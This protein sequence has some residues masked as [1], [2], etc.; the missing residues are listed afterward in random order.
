MCLW[1]LGESSLYRRGC[2]DADVMRVDAFVVS[3][4]MPFL[5]WCTKSEER[6]SMDS[7]CVEY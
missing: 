3:H 4:C 7:A 2:R 5:F 6:F 1:G